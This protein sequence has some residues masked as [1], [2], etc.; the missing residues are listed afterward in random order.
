[1]IV[2]LHH[3]GRING[4]GDAPSMTVLMTGRQTTQLAGQPIHHLGNAS[5]GRGGGTFSHQHATTGQLHPGQARDA[6]PTAWPVYIA[7]TDVDGP[8]QVS[9][10]RKSEACSSSGKLD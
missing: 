3:P 9:K 10:A 4:Q 8:H 7:K 2:T 6:Q 1:M 5:L